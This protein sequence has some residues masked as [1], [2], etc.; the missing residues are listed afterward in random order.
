LILSV[1]ATNRAAVVARSL[2]R[3]LGI[4]LSM[5]FPEL[6][7]LITDS[8]VIGHGERGSEDVEECEGRSKGSKYVI[9]VVSLF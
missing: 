3:I 2:P 7:H 8:L 4:L 9:S 1:A 6:A 5:A